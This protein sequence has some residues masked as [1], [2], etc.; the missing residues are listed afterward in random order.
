VIRA[1][2]RFA[3][4]SIADPGQLAALAERVLAAAETSAVVVGPRPATMLVALTESVKGQPFNLGE[5]VVTEATVVVNGCHGDGVV[6]GRDHER[7]TAAAVCDAA[8]EAG[9]LSADIDRL[10][11][12][13]EQAQA[14][15]RAHAAAA[16]ADTRVSVEVIS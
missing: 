10:V 4:L 14:V 16:V 11:R 5:V 6:L 15:R 1:E 7:A 12:E 9:L 13:T 3:A 2:R 8:A